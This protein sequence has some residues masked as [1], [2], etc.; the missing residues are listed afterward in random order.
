MPSWKTVWQSR[1]KAT[2]FSP[3]TQQPLE[4]LF[5]QVSRKPWFYVQTNPARERRRRRHARNAARQKDTSKHAVRDLEEPRGGRCERGAY[6]RIPT[7][8]ASGK[9]RTVETGGGSG[10]VRHGVGE[11]GTLEGA[12]TVAAC[13]NPRNATAHSGSP[14]ADGGFSENASVC[15]TTAT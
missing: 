10:V 2:H 14:N 13:Q 11:G 15:L 8:R 6:C 4:L 3:P 9:G 1:T 7:T 5:P 12:I